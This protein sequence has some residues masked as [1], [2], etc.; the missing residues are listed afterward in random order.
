M[1]ANSILWEGVTIG[2]C[3]IVKGSV[4]AQNRTIGDGKNIK[5]ESVI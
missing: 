3:S 4:I 2:A 1:I 5:D